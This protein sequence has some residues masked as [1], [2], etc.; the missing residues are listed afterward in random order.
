[1]HVRLS[2][3]GF[4][5]YLAILFVGFLAGG[6]LGELVGRFLPEG[7]AKEFFLTSVVGEIGPFHLDLIALS[8]VVGPLS[9]TVNVLSLVALIGA[10]YLFR[11]FF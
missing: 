7:V 9:L 3:R 8:I 2:R 4:G 11:S 10:A 1:M 5:A 6:L